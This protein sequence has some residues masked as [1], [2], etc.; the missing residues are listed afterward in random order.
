MFNFFIKRS[1]ITLAIVMLLS[2]IAVYSDANATATTTQ[3]AVAGDINTNSSRISEPTIVED[4]SNM[5]TKNQVINS[6]KKESANDTAQQTRHAFLWGAASSAYQIEGSPAADGKG[7]SVWDYYLDEKSLAGPGISGN[8]AINFY[9]RQQYLQDITLFKEMGLTSYRFSISWPRIIPDGLGPVN[10]KG[11]EHY[12]QFIKDLKQA[13]IT[14]VLT[15]YHWDMPASLA[16]AGGWQNRQS[17]EWFKRY[18]EVVFANFSDLVDQYV[19]I[20]EP[21]VEIAQTFLAQKRLAGD[22]SSSQ[23]P[24]VPS[25]QYLEKSLKAYN[26]ILLSAAAA[27]EVFNEK[28]YTGKLGIAL[29]YF[30][31]LTGEN[32]SQLDKQNA[33]L[34]DG[35]LN[36]W[37][38]DAMYKGT[39]PEDVLK[40]VKDNQLNIDLEPND[41]DRIYKAG[42]GFLGINYYAPF[43]IQHNP[44]D[45]NDYAPEIFIPEGEKVAF[46]GAVRPEQFTSLLLRIK[47]NWGN[48]PVI[49]TEN[50]AGFPDEDV[51][52]NGKVNDTNRCLYLVNHINAMQD[53]IKQG[54][55][56]QGYHVWSSH[57]NLEWLS[58]YKSRFGIIYV[59]YDT[60]Q[61]TPKM[62]AE[63]YSHIIK[64]E[65]I[66]PL[67][68]Q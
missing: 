7:R 11:V 62:S 55:N 15:L 19:L 38:L 48:P 39:Y 26:H 46:N 43:F 60:Q 50:G 58:G 52:V 29:P 66:S 1:I 33:T 44:N 16:A 6:D 36:R 31:I 27:Q 9:D 47:D 54:A 63:I 57:D 41:A 24:I 2:L 40:L 34:V 37:F 3:Q 25:L 56:V 51:L 59:D 12:R 61:R 22:F 32:A 4:L 23:P 10:L 67:D 5:L 42:L 35:V 8:A 65:N 17:V 20:N 68:C 64:G 49:I 53:A 30:P 13:G 21:T 18:A 28:K 45:T 14:P